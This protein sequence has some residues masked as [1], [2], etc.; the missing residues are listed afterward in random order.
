MK[1]KLYNNFYKYSKILNKMK[2]NPNDILPELYV[3]I[4]DLNIEM[5]YSKFY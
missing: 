5:F 1:I 2:K 3:K 4:Y